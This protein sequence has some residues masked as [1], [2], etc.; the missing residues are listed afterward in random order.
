MT[1][2]GAPHTSTF[3]DV[4]W[5]GGVLDIVVA[6]EGGRERWHWWDRIEI[7]LVGLGWYILVGFE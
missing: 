6:L 3:A 4:V 7:V 1:F 5:D 2:F